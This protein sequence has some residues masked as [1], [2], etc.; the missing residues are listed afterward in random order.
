MTCDCCQERY[1][2]DNDLVLFGM[3]MDGNGKRWAL[4]GPCIQV[5]WRARAPRPEII[6]V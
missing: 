2:D 4:C 3:L 5:I 1:E 6:P